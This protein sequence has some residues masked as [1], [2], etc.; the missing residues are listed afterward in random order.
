MSPS[1]LV[2]TVVATG[3]LS[4][5]A[6]AAPVDPR[7]GGLEV[8]LGV[9]T[10]IPEATAIRPGQVTFIVRNR[11]ASS[12]TVRATTRSEACARRSS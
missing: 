1:L 8:A 3:A 4:S 6:V 5:P 12:R 2:L 11:S 10:L 9:W 7:A